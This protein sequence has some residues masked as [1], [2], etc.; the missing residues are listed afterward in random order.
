VSTH[1]RSALSVGIPTFGTA[2]ARHGHDWR[3]LL[4]LARMAEDAGVDRLVVSDHV[5]LGPNTDA[6]PWGT[7]PTGPEADWLEPLT[8]VTALAAVTT[9]V[10]FLTGVLVAPLRPAALLAK[11]VATVDVLSDGRLDLGVGTGWQPEEFI[12]V[13]TSFASR[14]DLLTE[15]IATCRQLWTGGPVPMGDGDDATTVW[16][17]PVPRQDPLPVWF[18]GTLTAR[19]VRR[20]VEL[21]DGWIPIMG[22]D[23]AGLADGV[24]VLRA[25]FAEAGRDPSTL[26]VRAALPVARDGDGRADVDRTLAAAPDLMLAG[27]TDLHLPLRAFDPD[28][29]HPADTFARLVARYRAETG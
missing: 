23:A 26:G 15:G 12:A 20:I 3:H 11:T 21:G 5:V 22:T 14:G 7:F 18:S 27:A 13:G 25:A 8:V 28:G 9:T 4:D 6:Y 29:T 10:R 1:A 24:A 19:N 16:C 2:A 17:A